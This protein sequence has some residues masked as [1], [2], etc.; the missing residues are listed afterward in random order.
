MLALSPNTNETWI[1][2]TNRSQDPA[3]W[4][5]EFV[6]EEHSGQV[7]GIDWCPETNLIVT[8]SHDRNAYV[9]KFDSANNSWKPT[10]V[11][12]RI[13]RAA[14]CVKWSPAG[15]KFAVGS[16][17][18]CVPVC[19]FEESNDWWISKMIKKHKSTVLSL[20]WCVNNKFLVT[21]SADMKARI[22]SA[23]M[24]GIDPAEDDGF[25][26][27]FGAVKQHEF[28]EV[29]AE[30][31]AAHAWVHAVAWSPGGF[32]LAF[33]GHGS[34]VHFV[35]LLAGSDPVVKTIKNPHLPYVDLQF[36]SDN[37]L[38]GVGFDFNVDIFEAKGD[39]ADP[40]WELT[41]RL[42][43]AESKKAANNTP[44]PGGAGA[45]RALFANA[46]TRGVQ[47]GQVEADTTIA[48]KHKN[49]IVNV[50]VVPDASG[51]PSKVT[52]AGID[53]RIIFWDLP[54]LK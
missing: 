32:R 18:K 16:G 53:G 34:T 8:C 20:S 40:S 9:W 26:E 43:K 52:T 48:T 3:K 28:G 36:L 42:D 30:F 46:A 1:Y 33:A 14:T 39:E 4:K 19:H 44:A 12:L 21:G 54:K 37:A 50:Q 6:L 41:N 27:V 11:V 25:G 24:E 45:A 22:F 35:Q 23:Y 29:L 15:N 7:S 49:L 17:A 31:D 51:K 38:V 13:N 2:S 5:R 47:F 10:L